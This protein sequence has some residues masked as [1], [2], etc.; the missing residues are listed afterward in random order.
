MAAPMLDLGVVLPCV[1]A[2]AQT[3]DFAATANLQ[4]YN[5]WDGLI[6]ARPALIWLGLLS[7]LSVLKPDYGKFERKLAETGCPEFSVVWA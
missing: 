4:V 5:A 6:C 3:A 2:K 7:I 1:G